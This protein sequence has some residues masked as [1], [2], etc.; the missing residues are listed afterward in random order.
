MKIVLEVI[1][2]ETITESTVNYYIS[3]PNEPVAT[4]RRMVVPKTLAAEYQR[5]DTGEVTRDDVTNMPLIS[6]D[7]SV[8]EAPKIGPIVMTWVPSYFADAKTDGGGTRGAWVAAGS[9]T[10]LTPH[11]HQTSAEGHLVGFS[12]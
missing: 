7:D 8:G 5:E 1:D 2:S 12:E 11:S 9:G 6:T 10:S 3:D 4:D